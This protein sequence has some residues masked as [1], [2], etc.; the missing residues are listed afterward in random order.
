MTS[1]PD[2]PKLPEKVEEK[3]ID[4]DRKSA[5]AYTLLE[6]NGIILDQLLDGSVLDELDMT[7]SLIH[8]VRHVVQA[9]PEPADPVIQDAG[10]A[11]VDPET[12]GDE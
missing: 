3:F 8:E 4:V 7:E 5:A 6:H 2:R 10:R 1:N 11:V 12:G 9:T